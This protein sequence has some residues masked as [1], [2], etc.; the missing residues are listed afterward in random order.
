MVSPTT[1]FTEAMLNAGEVTNKGVELL[2][3]IT[4]IRTRDF[5]WNSTVNFARNDNVVTELYGDLQ[6]VVLGTYWSATV[7][8]RVGERYGAI[9]GNPWTR[10]RSGPARRECE[11][12][13]VPRS[14]ADRA[15]PLHARL[16]RR[17]AEPVPLPEHGHE[18]PLRHSAGGPALLGHQPVRAVRG[19]SRGDAAGPLQQGGRRGADGSHGRHAGV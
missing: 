16:D 17:L 11:R 5:E 18:L 2:T 3:T 4:P 7:Q 1:G 12:T 14:A 13:P 15:R 9:V 8:A 10:D 6:S 19:R